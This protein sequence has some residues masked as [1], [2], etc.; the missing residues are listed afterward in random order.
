MS[1]PYDKED[2]KTIE[3]MFDNIAERY[4]VTNS[5][6]SFSL[7]KRWNHTLVKEVLLTNPNHTYLDLCAGTGDIAFDYLHSVTTPCRSYLMDFSAEMLEK[8]KIKASKKSFSLNNLFYIKGDVQEI[9]LGDQ[10]VDCATMAY[11]IRNVQHPSKCIKEVFRVLKPGGNFGILEL[12]RPKNR[13]LRLGHH[14]YLTKILPLLGKFLTN[15]K[16]AYHYLCQSIDQ[17]I[18]PLEVQELMAKEGF[19]TIK[20]LPLLGGVATILIGRKPSKELSF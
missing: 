18:S 5:I 16:D 20:Q 12:T 15:N 9:P 8:A 10:S 4:D 11:G 2:P 3:S 1:H 14:F 13:F 19:S 6:L 17:F 7:H